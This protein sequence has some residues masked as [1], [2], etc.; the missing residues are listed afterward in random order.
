[1]ASRRSDSACWREAP[2]GGAV[3][4][5]VVGRLEQELLVVV[6]HVQPA[7]EVGKADRHRLDPLLVGQI[8]HPLLADLV[9]IG[10]G[11]PLGLGLEVHLLEPVV[12][13]FQEIAQFG[14]GLG[15]GSGQELDQGKRTNLQNR[16]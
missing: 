4:G 14:H 13:D 8:L 15:P 6:Q 12:G 3:E 7:F 10:P 2:D 1:M 11:R 5:Q 16:T 9:G